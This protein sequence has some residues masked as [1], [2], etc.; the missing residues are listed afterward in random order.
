MKTGGTI[1]RMQRAA[2]ALQSAASALKHGRQHTFIEKLTTATQ[3]ITD[4]VC[5]SEKITP[6]ERVKIIMA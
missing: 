3:L 6:E 4:V 2:E 5:S 1:D